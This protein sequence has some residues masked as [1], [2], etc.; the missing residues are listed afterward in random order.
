VFNDGAFA[1]LT[2]KETAAF[3][4]IP[5]VHGEP[6]RFGP[7]H[8]RLV[9]RRPDGTLAIADEGE[10]VVHDAHRDDPALAFALARLA[11]SPSDPTPIGVL[12]AVDHPVGI[13]ETGARLA[14]ARAELAPG[15]LDELLHAGDT[16]TVTY[17][18]SS[19]RRS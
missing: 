5:L 1:P 12:R 4:R 3:T 10:P 15:T 13:R 17:S 16:W 14:A 9:V 11:D 2:D 7:D 8:E 6:I 19:T 18:E